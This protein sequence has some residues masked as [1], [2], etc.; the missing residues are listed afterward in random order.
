LIGP[1]FDGSKKPVPSSVRRRHSGLSDS[2]NGFSL[3][4]AVLIDMIP[5][6]GVRDSV[7]ESMSPIRRFSAGYCQKREGKE[8]S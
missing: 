8:S 5:S 6:Q 1:R 2:Y 7:I 4:S 3:P